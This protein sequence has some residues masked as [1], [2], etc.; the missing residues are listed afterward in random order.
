MYWK[1]LME[2]LKL[3]SYKTEFWKSFMKNFL[4]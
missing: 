1:K 2:L 4:M 3:V